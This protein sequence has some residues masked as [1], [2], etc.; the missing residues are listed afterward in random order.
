MNNQVFVLGLGN[1]L[2]GDDGFGVH[3]C[4][5][6]QQN[7]SFPDHCTVIDGGTQ[8]QI[9]YGIVT[10]AKRLL[11]LDAANLGLEPG[12]L[13]MRRGEDIP[14][15]LSS[16]KLSAH[17]SSFA[18]VLALASLKGQ[19]PP[20]MVLIGFQPAGLEFGAK[21]GE[22]CRKALP[23]ALDMALEILNTWQ[24]EPV[25]MQHVAADQVSEA[26]RAFY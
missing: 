25:P 1:I 6:L 9:L 12:T 10:E 19:I 18:E 17:Q 3:C 4:R 26:V 24:I 2:C 21:L 22:E 5:I 16:R 15:W 8:G 11:I 7:F 14:A 13:A 23:R 20:E